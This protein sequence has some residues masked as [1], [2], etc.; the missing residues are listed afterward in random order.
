MSVGTSEVLPHNLYNNGE[1]LNLPSLISR[2]LSVH[3]TVFFSCISMIDI[4]TIVP[5]LKDIL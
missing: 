4:F 2:K 1:V 5:F 3:R